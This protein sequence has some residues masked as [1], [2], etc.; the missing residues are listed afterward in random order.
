MPSRFRTFGLIVLVAVLMGG[1]ASLQAVRET[2]FPPP[3]ATEDALYFTS[4][5]TVQRLAAGYSAIAADLY[6]VRAIQYYGG[7]KLRL[8]QT[9]PAASQALA[10]WHRW[11]CEVSRAAAGAPSRRSAA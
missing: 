11:M 10:K 9:P 1:A 2:R 8:Q 5:K 6:W 3:Q 4:G 7:V